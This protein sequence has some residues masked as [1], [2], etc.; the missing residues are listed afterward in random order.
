[1]A[2]SMS[3]TLA[4]GVVL[5]VEIGFATSAG[6][7]TVPIN[8]TL[9]SITWTD[10]SADVRSCSMNRGRSSELDAFN[11]GSCQI[12]LANADRRF[13]PEHTAGPYY[14]KLT[15]GR[16]IR[17]RATPPSG[18]ATGIFFGFVDQWNQLYNYPNDA[19][20]VV[21]ASDAFKV[22]NLITLPS[23]WQYTIANSAATSWWQ[24]DDPIGSSQP[25]ES[26]RKLYLGAWLSGSGD[27][28]SSASGPSLLVDTP[29]T[30]AQFDGNRWVRIPAE[31][32]Q[33]H[34]AS[35]KMSYEFWFKT[36]TTTDG[37]YSLFHKGVQ[38]QNSTVGMV[39]SSGVG[40]IQ[41]QWGDADNLPTFGSTYI[42]TSPIQVNDGNT[43]HV[44][45]VYDKSTTPK[46]YECWVDGVQ[47]TLATTDISSASY[48]SSSLDRNIAKSTSNFANSAYNFPN[49]FIGSIDE[50]VVYDYVALS[51]SQ[52][53][54]HYKIG[55]GQYLA[56]QTTS[57]RITTLLG[58]AGWMSDGTN[59]L[60]GSST[61]QGIQC[62]NDTLLS[63]L[64]ECESAEQG[65]LFIDGNG[66][67]AFIGRQSLQTVSN[68]NTPQRTF[69][70]SAGELPYA[71][72][73]FVYNDQL[74]KNQFRVSRNG[75]LTVEVNDATSQGQYFIRSGSLTDL[76]VDNDAFLF[77]LANA[78]VAFYKQPALRIQSMGVNPR[79]NTT[80]YTG[81][82]GDEIGTRITVNRRPQSVGSVISKQLLIEGVSHEI[83]PQTWTA[84]YNLSPAPLAFFV[85]D[86][87]TFGV[88]DTNMLGY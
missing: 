35:S 6:D 67:V 84:T 70:D 5:T 10:V 77:D 56:G 33:G 36:T 62:Y 22:M 15:P 72:L 68:Y 4:D 43:H 81:L 41:A 57:E 64:K 12:T 60:A 20:A 32:M 50:F 65:R 17:I 31:S 86:S 28:S 74:I 39:V 45:M 63:A 52:I 78:L 61:M 25:F 44:V 19:I 40:T 82:I 69:G 49:N 34:I 24:F 29:G 21:T 16:P 71:N 87:S 46:R 26:I 2:G 73:E 1:V 8:S 59:L 9:A 66:K 58:L 85:L 75:G 47:A 38:R 11:A 76:F 88:L 79:A 7:N 27:Q 3:V 48:G 42:L 30:S 23:Y 83:G 55:V 37:N 14:G 80:I 53:A 13:D 54:D 18:S 51:T